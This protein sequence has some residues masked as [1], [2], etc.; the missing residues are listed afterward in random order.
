MATI[1][2]KFETSSA[3]D[4]KEE[5]RKALNEGATDPKGM[6]KQKIKDALLF[7]EGY[8]DM[9]YGFGDADLEF[10]DGIKVILS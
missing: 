3:A 1:T 2:I 10:A 4:R 6:F 7:K 8:P 9:E 5:I